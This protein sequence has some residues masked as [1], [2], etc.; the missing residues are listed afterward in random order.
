LR[1]LRRN[2]YKLQISGDREEGVNIK[3]SNTDKDGEERVYRDYLGL[4]G[5]KYISIVKELYYL[6]F[7]EELP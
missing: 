4:K 3:N 7:Q 1:I 6:A 2:I 5:L